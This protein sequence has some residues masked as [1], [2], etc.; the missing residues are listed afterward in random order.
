ML[1]AA[2]DMTRFLSS[3]WSWRT[4]WAYLG[5]LFIKRLLITAK[6]F[7]AVTLQRFWKGVDHLQH[8]PAPSFLMWTGEGLYTSNTYRLHCGGPE[9]VNWRLAKQCDQ[10]KRTVITSNCPSR[11]RISVPPS[12]SP[13]V[14]RVINYYNNRMKIH[15]MIVHIT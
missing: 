4:R 13:C 1:M 14:A 3:S 6:L 7:L 8:R 10:Y 2:G 15:Y 11:A 9:G 12:P 5:M